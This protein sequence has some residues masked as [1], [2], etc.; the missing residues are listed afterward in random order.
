VWEDD[1]LKVAVDIY[2]IEGIDFLPDDELAEEMDMDCVDT[3]TDERLVAEAIAPTEEVDELKVAVDIYLDEGTIVL[4]EDELAEKIAI[5]CVD[6]IA[7]EELVVEA[8][9]LLRELGE[10]KDAI[11]IYVDEGTAVLPDDE[12][13]ENLGID[14]VDTIADEGLVMEATELTGKV[15]ADLVE[16]FDGLVAQEESL[17]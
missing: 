11:D 15:G 8:T 13:A 7:D 5:D 1:E 16:V 14:C 6:T 17:R 9:E 4:P 3:I 10:L 12:L 2:F